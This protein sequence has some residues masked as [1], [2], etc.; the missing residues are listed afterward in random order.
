MYT[1]KACFSK[2]YHKMLSQ[3]KSFSLE[4]CLLRLSLKVPFIFIG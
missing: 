1:E 3:D 2:K 4:D